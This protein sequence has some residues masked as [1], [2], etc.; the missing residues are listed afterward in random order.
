M[1]LIDTYIPPADKPAVGGAEKQLYLLAAKLDRKRFR[2]IVVQLITSED[3]VVMVDKIGTAELLHFPTKRFYSPHGINQIL[4]ISRLA[5]ERRVDIIHTFFEKSE[6]VGWA[7]ARLSGTPIWITSRRDLGFKRKAVYDRI[8]RYTSKDCALCIANCEAIRNM[9]IRK[10][11][12]PPGK[13]VTSWNGLDLFEFDKRNNCTDLRSEI[14]VDGKFPIVGMV[15]NFNFGI[16]GQQYFIEAAK[17]I[18]AEIP[19]ARFVLVGDGSLR[20]E[21]ERQ[22]EELGLRGK[23]K[24]LGKRNDVTGILRELSVSVLCST[25]EGFSNVILESMAAGRPV[26]ATDVGGNPEL[27]E[28]GITG[29]VVPPADSGALANAIVTLLRA[30]DQRKAMGSLGRAKVKKNFS[31]ASMVESHAILYESLLL[32][33]NNS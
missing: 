23:V 22:V 2:A 6:V 1:Y 27:V 31:V 18:A 4:R 28:D 9:V 13:V 33:G 14:G 5:R 29:F 8:F 7:V 15:A 10:E 12:L 19:E 20:H 26:V 16:K 11:G 17:R 21:R 25:S 30:P 3:T 24:F 32:R